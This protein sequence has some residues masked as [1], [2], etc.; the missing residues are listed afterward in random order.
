MLGYF[1]GETDESI[2]IA[3]VVFFV[4]GC[5][6]GDP[7]MGSFTDFTFLYNSNYNNWKSSEIG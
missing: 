5:I 4:C 1:A 2:F 3:V 7:P 6:I